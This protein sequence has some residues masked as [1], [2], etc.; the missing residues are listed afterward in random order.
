MHILDPPNVINRIHKNP[1]ANG[2]AVNVTNQMSFVLRRVDAVVRI[3]EL[4]PQ[5]GRILTAHGNC[6]RI[7]LWFFVRKLVGIVNHH[8]LQRTVVV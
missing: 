8:T 3:Q 2:L 4:D 1:T 5:D 6:I 7:R